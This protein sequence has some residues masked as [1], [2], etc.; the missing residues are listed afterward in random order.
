[1]ILHTLEQQI[2]DGISP[3]KEELSML[4]ILQSSVG[5]ANLCE[6][7]SQGASP[8]VTRI[9]RN[10]LSGVLRGLKRITDMYGKEWVLL[11]E[12]RTHKPWIIFP[13]LDTDVGS[14]P[15]LGYMVETLWRDFQCKTRISTVGFSRH[16]KKLQEM[17][18]DIANRLRNSVEGFRISL[19]PY[20]AHFFSDDY[21]VDISNLINTYL[22]LI[23]SQWVGRDV[24]ACELRF[25]PFI[26]LSDVEVWLFHGRFFIRSGDYCFIA[27]YSDTVYQSV[28]S[29]LRDKKVEF[30]HPG[31]PGKIY[32]WNGFS[33]KGIDQI[34]E[35]SFCREANIYHVK[36]IDWDVFSINPLADETWFHAIHFLPRSSTRTHSGIIDS[37]RPFMNAM[38]AYKRLRWFQTNTKLEWWNIED[39]MSFFSA[40]IQNH[41]HSQALCN[42]WNNEIFPVILLASKIIKWSHISDDAFFDPKF[43]VDTWGIVNQGRA[44]H[45]FQWLVS[46]NDEPIT[47]NEM[48]GYAVE[49]SLGTSRGIIYRIA[50]VP[51]NS[52]GLRNL[53]RWKSG[54]VL[55]GLHHKWLQ[56]IPEKTHFIPADIETTFTPRQKIL[57][58]FGIPWLPLIS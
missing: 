19:T 1:M 23:E 46:Q 5:C 20:T 25:P 21:P 42:F 50:P 56:P 51:M 17:H 30:D 43:L 37:T 16:N 18:T 28:I 4:Q 12:N 11:G 22:P 35:T 13:Y 32:L 39:F 47:I 53:I 57:T 41:T 6:M 40:Y 52:G 44:K 15:N 55:S 49:N 45:I 10:S 31:V 14:D 7:C 27:D 33:A 8:W 36:N 29:G 24:F 48:K 54:L 26:Q 2:F 3:F 9:T 34:I 38:I 58:E